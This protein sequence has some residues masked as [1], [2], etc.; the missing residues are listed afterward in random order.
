MTKKKITKADVLRLFEAQPISICPE[1]K[2]E[3]EPKVVYR[4]QPVSFVPIPGV[5]NSA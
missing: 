1:P 2:D 5:T 3:D 4:G